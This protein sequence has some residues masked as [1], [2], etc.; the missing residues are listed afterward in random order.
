[1]GPS[2][3]GRAKRVDPR[4][5]IRE[6]RS[7]GEAR[8]LSRADRFESADS[9]GP[10]RGGRVE[11]ADPI[12]PTEEAE[13]QR[14]Q[15]SKKPRAEALERWRGQGSECRAHGSVGGPSELSEVG[16]AKNEQSGP[17]LVWVEPSRSGRAEQRWANALEKQG[18][19]MMKT[20]EDRCRHR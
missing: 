3:C 6:G 11:G 18:E 16:R 20:G 1:M 14:I 2:R 17:S 10:S 7:D 5:S 13:R 9:R 19:D 8:G 15:L 4:G 12:G